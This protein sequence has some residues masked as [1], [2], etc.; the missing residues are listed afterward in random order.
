MTE[1][2][3]PIFSDE[4]VDEL[5]RRYGSRLRRI[6]FTVDGIPSDEEVKLTKDIWAALTDG[7]RGHAL[8]NISHMVSE[9]EGIP[10][11]DLPDQTPYA[12]RLTHRFLRIES[13]E[14]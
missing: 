4:R 10:L 9:E 6:P 3:K 7:E 2:L 13:T 12:M 8:D 5:L 1:D 14:D 11:E